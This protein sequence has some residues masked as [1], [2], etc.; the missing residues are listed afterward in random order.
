MTIEV[1]ASG[2]NL[3]HVDVLVHVD[4]DEHAGISL[5]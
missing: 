4:E 1:R 5:T 2:P 3:V